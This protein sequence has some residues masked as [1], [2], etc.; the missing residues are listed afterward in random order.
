[1]ST[2]TEVAGAGG[3]IAGQWL[4]RIVGGAI[5]TLV[6]PEGTVIG[7]WIG[8][9]VG[10]VAGRATASAIASYMESANADAEKKTKEGEQAK[11]CVDCG[12]IDCFN[13]PEGADDK[14]KEEFRRQLKEQQ[15]EINRMDPDDLIRNMDNYAKNGRPE[16]DAADRRLARESYRRARERELS[17]EYQSQGKDNFE[18][19]AAQEVAKELSKLAA[20]H[21]LDLVAGG[22]GSISGL[23]NK[24][25]NSSLGAQWKGRR[26]AQL[27]AHAQKAKEQGKKMNAKLEECPP[28]SGSGSSGADGNGG[29]TGAGKGK[30]AGDIP[31]S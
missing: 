11:P 29:K 14:T 20:T 15:D 31:T 23:G 25:I 28:K 5:G 16:N 26:A 17:D 2:T 24:T 4:G 8:G 3:A 12:E 13:P 10:A 21:T 19:L 7:G 27:K 1:M 6:G 30:G 18:E 9:R 22:D